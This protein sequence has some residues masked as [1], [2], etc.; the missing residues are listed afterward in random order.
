MARAALTTC[1]FQLGRMRPTKADQ[2]IRLMAVLEFLSFSIAQPTTEVQ[3]TSYHRLCLRRSWRRFAV[4]V[5]GG[6]ARRFFLFLVRLELGSRG[7]FAA[8]R[9]ETW[10]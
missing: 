7:C 10:V 9:I 8:D 2:A 1:S 4:L 3:L 6:L 5:P